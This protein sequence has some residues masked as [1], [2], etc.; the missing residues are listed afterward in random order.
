MAERVIRTVCPHDCPDQCSIL[1]TVSDDGRLLRVAGNPQHSFTAGF[2]CGKVNRYPERVHSTE[3]LLT[4]LRR[5]GPKGSGEFAPVSWEAALEEIAGRWQAIVGRH[6]GEA[7][8][9]YAYGGNHGL[10]ARNV[11]RA[12]FHALGATRMIH[13]TVCDT[14]AEAGWAY[15]CGET[16]GTDPE[17]V[18]RADLIL[19]WGCNPVSTNVHLIPFID[20]ARRRGAQLVVVDPYQS[21][22]ARQADWHLAPRLG[23]D[24]ALALGLMH[25]LVREGLQDAGYLARH[26]VGFDALCAQVLPAYDPERVA[27][28]TGLAAAD[29]ERLA[30]LYGRAGAPFLRLGTGLSRHRGGGMAVRTVALLPAVVGAW[31]KPGGGCLME[32]ASAWG[33]DYD[34]VRRPDLLPRPVREVNQSHLGR[35]LLTLQ[36]PPILGLFIAGTNP[37]V[38]CPDAGAVAAGL[39]REDLFTVVHDSFLTDTARFADMVLPASTAFEQEDIYRA[40]GTYYAQY[41]PQVVPPQGE[42][43][44]NLAVVQALAPRLGLDDPFFR[45]SAPELM[46]AL[47]DGASGPTAAITLAALRQGPVRLADPQT[48]PERIYFDSEAMAA[49][50]LPAL[51]GLAREPAPPQGFPLRLLTAPGHTLHHTSFAPVAALVRQEG[52]PCVLLHPADAASRGVEHGD[53]VALRSEHGRVLLQARVTA[54]TQ[55]GLVV[56]E[57]Q[58]N[59]AGYAGGGPLNLLTGDDLA[60]MGAG[61]TYQDTWVEVERHGS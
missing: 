1:A 4:P 11:V 45:R 8:L 30:L 48:G 44:S 6:G 28:L 54:G 39:S 3:R 2:L 42:A 52:P 15:A 57:G 5:T 33:F 36:D 14:T 31:G 46:Q 21:R 34:A 37:A 18:E 22:T 61:A 17:S 41:G 49:A 38:S 51:P 35:A 27:A 53:T 55:P 60:D 56:V 25:V 9:G 24:T 26:A 59:R 50:G 43:R 47:L 20:R 40:Y 19:C 7:L 12:L 29:I 13:G 32:T 10:V 23:T 16:P 58:R